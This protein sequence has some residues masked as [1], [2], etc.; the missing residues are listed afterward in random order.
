LGSGNRLDGGGKDIPVWVV[1]RIEASPLCLKLVA[2]NELE[3][4]GGIVI[5]VDV[6]HF[7]RSEMVSVRPGSSAEEHT[8]GV[9]KSIS[10]QFPI[11]GI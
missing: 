3:G 9:S 6:I 1:A 5:S 4:L 7:L 8:L 11:F 2:K 10:P